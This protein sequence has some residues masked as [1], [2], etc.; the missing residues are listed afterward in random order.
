MIFISEGLSTFC[1]RVR[2]YRLFFDRKV[3]VYFISSIRVL[4][5]YPGRMRILLLHLVQV[6]CTVP[7][8]WI[9]PPMPSA[10]DRETVYIEASGYRPSV[11]QIIL[12]CIERFHSFDRAVILSRIRAVIP[13]LGVS[14]ET[15]LLSID[16]HRRLLNY[17]SR[18]PL[19]LHELL[20]EHFPL[21]PSIAIIKSAAPPDYPEEFFRIMGPVTRGWSRFCISRLTSEPHFCLPVSSMHIH[22]KIQSGYSLTHRGLSHMLSSLYVEELRKTR[23]VV[24]DFDITMNNPFSTEKELEMLHYFFSI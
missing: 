22:G 20:V 12:S 19:W 6:S 8:D 9:L 23:M 11:L 17:M 4:F 13:D 5:S 2:I 16:K 21:L 3:S 7:H 1:K 18:V 14:D 24:P 15:L 10:S